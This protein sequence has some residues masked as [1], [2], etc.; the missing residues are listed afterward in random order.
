MME[1]L[2]R[3]RIARMLHDVPRPAVPG[4]GHQM[5]GMSDFRRL[6]YAAPLYAALDLGTHNCRLMVA[7]PAGRGF[8]VIDSF[9]RVVRLGEGL[10]HTGRLGQDAMARTADALRACALRM[11]RAG[12][13]KYTAIATEACRRAENGL[14]F[15]DG[16]RD[17]TGLSISI[18]SAREEAEL[19]LTSCASLLH[20]GR[21]SP[22]RERALLFDIGGGSTEI[23][24]VRTD[25]ARARQSLIGYLSL[26]MGV[27]TISEQLGDSAFTPGGYRHMVAM[28]RAQ[29]E[30]FE[31][32]HCIRRE[33][34]CGNVV[35][36][37]TSGTVTTLA[38]VAL[39]QVRYDRSMIDGATLSMTQ[40]L[41]VIRRLNGMDRAG[42]SG[43]V[44]IG[45][46]RARYIMAGCAIF[47]AIQQAWQV[48]E[49]V[50]AD[51]GLRDGMLLRMIDRSSRIALQPVPSSFSPVRH[52]LRPTNGPLHETTTSRP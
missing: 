16:I 49:V 3:Q 6:P 34:A 23:A 27:I 17:E 33:I 12:L 10:H 38:S 5:F 4:Q 35:L 32:V 11:R 13:K 20:D 50:V 45:P 18:I 26:P 28:V 8:R 40:A 46:D 43:H 19:A 2:E 24:W 21:F 39:G 42:L 31:D 15:L 29:L 41:K 22:L 52:K 1:C 37:G 9:S 44:G 25:H 51:R 14:A 30:A 47:E 36:M 48:P 7:A